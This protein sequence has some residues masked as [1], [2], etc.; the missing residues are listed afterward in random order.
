MFT[1]YLFYPTNMIDISSSQ[2]HISEFLDKHRSG[3]LATADTLGK[4]HA[5]SVYITYDRNLNIY[6]VTKADTQKARNIQQNPHA[7]I[8]ISDEATLTTVQGLGPVSKITD[9][10]R[11][12]DIITEI[13]RIALN[14]SQSHIP[15]TSRL[16]AGGY[17][18]YMLSAPSLRMATFST[19]NADDDIFETAHTEPSLS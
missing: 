1:S 14:S 2:K 19:A 5:A 18:V 8:A 12:N 13:W 4:P 16:T 7:A 15:P 11:A 10:E 3:V 6:F 17:V 9:H